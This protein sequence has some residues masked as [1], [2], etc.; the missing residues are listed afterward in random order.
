MNEISSSKLTQAVVGII[1]AVMVLGIVLV[2]VL[3]QATETEKTFVNNGGFYPMKE[4]SATDEGTYTLEWEKTNTTELTINGVTFDAYGSYGSAITTIAC[5]DD[6]I[7]RYSSADNQYGYCQT[8]NGVQWAGDGSSK[9]LTATAANGTLTVNVVSGSDTTITRTYTYDTMYAI[10][11]DVSDDIMKKSTE[12]PYVKGDS[13]LY[14]M[15]ITTGITGLVKVEG[16]IDDGVTVDVIGQDDEVVSNIVIDKT[17]VSGYNDLYTISKITFD[18][19]IGGTTT[20]CVYSYFIVPYEVIAELSDHPTSMMI[21]LINI[22]PV[23]V[24]LAIILGVCGLFYYRR[25]ENSLI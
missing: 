4:I 8:Y 6:W 25:N 16:N 10:D 2:P 22:I 20:N 19:E 1:V 15:G 13:T 17:P 14:A 7:I 24:V 3:S 18:V 5:G 12:T 21:T 23:F 9:S 11:T